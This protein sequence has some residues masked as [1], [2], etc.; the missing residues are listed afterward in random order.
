MKHW[1][2]DQHF[3]SLLKNTSYLA[4]SK[5][6]AAIAGIATLAFAGRA[7]GLVQFGLLVLISSYAQAA[8]GL[9]KFQSWQ[10]IIRY[11]GAA[12]TSGD[13]ATFKKSVGFG[14]GL[15]ISSGLVGMAGAMLLLPFIGPWTGIKANLIPVAMAFC[16]LVPTKGAAAPIGVLRALDRF[17]LIGWQGTTTQISRAI[18]AGF[19]WMLH[20][21]IEAFV[22]IWFVT[23]LGSD[24]FLWFLA[25]RELRRKDMLSG[26]RPTL[27]PKGLPGAWPFAIQVNVHSSLM[28]AWGPVGRVIIGGLLGPASAALYRVAS[29]LA[30]A[31]QKPADLIAKAYYPEIVRMDLATKQPWKLMVRGT[32]MASAFS[33]LAVLIVIVIGKWMLAQMF[34]PE[35]VPAYPVLLI[36]IGIPLLWMV[37]F[38]LMPM[39]YALDRADAPLKARAIGTVVYLAIVAP[40]SWRFD[41][42]GAAAAILIGNLI[43]V[44]ILMWWLR[45]EYRKVRGR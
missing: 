42:A 31:A 5:G 24:L 8:S 44:A 45:I 20:W 27:K 25:G 7:L 10:L 22:G 38:P 17:D 43:I 15:D 11:G 30:D 37:G 33:M 40:L 1:F 6:V 18:L 32:A 35:F 2:K 23:D 28:S 41:V 12:L 4:V 21:P 3:R 34:G 13:T 39:L 14:L 9:T 19:G 29:S 36:L 16:L 26:I